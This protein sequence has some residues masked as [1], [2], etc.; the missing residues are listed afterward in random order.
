MP[1]HLG[2]A[3]SSREAQL[4]QQLNEAR[5]EI[6]KLRQGSSQKLYYFVFTRSFAYYTGNESRN[7]AD[8]PREVPI[9]AGGAAAPPDFT[10]GAGISAGHT[11]HACRELRSH[12][13][14]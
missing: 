5:E 6:E 10:R 9:D 13:L 11:A 3:H 4:R 12:G 2:S 8:A 7:N 1:H 14:Y